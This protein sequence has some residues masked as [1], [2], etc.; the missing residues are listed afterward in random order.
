MS[1]NFYNG[2][3]YGGKKYK[4]FLKNCIKLSIPIDFFEIFLYL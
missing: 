1:P 2:K 4:N 3:F